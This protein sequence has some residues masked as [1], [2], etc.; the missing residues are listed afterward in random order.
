VVKLFYNHP[1]D[2]RLLVFS[3]ILVGG[4]NLGYL[5]ILLIS[6]IIFIL[7]CFLHYNLNQSPP[8]VQANAAETLC[9][10]S[11]NAPSALATQLSSPG[12]VIFLP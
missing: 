7:I 5:M 9:A 6:S 2:K 3:L 4:V 1:R 8:E 11:R 10:I 12:F